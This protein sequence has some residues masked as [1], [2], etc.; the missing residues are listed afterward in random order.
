[1][2]PYVP[3]AISLMAMKTGRCC[4][5][6]CIWRWSYKIRPRD[7]TQQINVLSRSV[8]QIVQYCALPTSLHVILV[9]TGPRQIAVQMLALLR[10]VDQIVQYCALPTSLHVILV[11]TGPR[12]MAVQMLALLI[13]TL[14][15]QLERTWR[16]WWQINVYAPC[17]L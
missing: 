8:D 14:H 5:R 10:S 3:T 17:I 12:Q 13:K 15:R 9:G 7:P 6:T 1:M 11:G 16:R 2:C 4:N